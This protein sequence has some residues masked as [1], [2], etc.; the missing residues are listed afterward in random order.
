MD[1]KG[2]LGDV[3]ERATIRASELVNT[4]GGKVEIVAAGE[5]MGVGALHLEC[6]M[7][8]DHEQRFAHAVPMPCDFASGR[9]LQKDSGRAFERVA[10][11]S[12]E[13]CARR[14]HRQGDEGAACGFG[15]TGLL[16]SI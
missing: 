5:F 12:G 3:E 7:A 6:G 13:L 10:V 11:I 4:F 1:V 8:A 9:S 14:Q 15:L 16:G 2:S